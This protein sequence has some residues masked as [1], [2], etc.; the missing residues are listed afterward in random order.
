MTNQLIPIEHKNQRVL[1]TQ[2]IADGYGT[3]TKNIQNNYIRNNER[4]LLGIHYYKLDG[5]ELQAFKADHQ[6]DDN[7]KYAPF[8]FLWT[9]KGALLHAKSLNTDKAWGVYGM[10]VDTYFRVQAL[11]LAP[12][13]TPDLA[14]EIARI[15]RTTDRTR[16][17]ILKSIFAYAGINFETLQITNGIE[18]HILDYIDGT[19]LKGIVPVSAV[20]HDYVNWCG[21][22]GLVPVSQCLFGH[23]IP[24][25]G[26]KKHRTRNT[27]FYSI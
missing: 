15:I 20:Y 26:I 2:Q 3:D 12:K 8:L 9:E 17:P 27:R 22:Q 11:P 21:Q 10:L 25:C 7:L 5:E 14:L 16:L 1:T 13:L 18:S 6:I 19:S 24:K 4:Y 23:R